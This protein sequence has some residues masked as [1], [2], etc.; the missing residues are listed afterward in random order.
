MT[1]RA[2]KLIIAVVI[3]LVVALFFVGI[4]AA[5]AVAGYRAAVRAGNEAATLQNLKTIAV[6]E[7]QYADSHN[8]NFA[9]LDDLVSEKLVSSKF[10]HCPTIADGY[11]I[12][13]T[14]APKPDGDSWYRLTADPQDTTSGHTHFYFDSADRRIH[15]NGERQ[16]GPT[17]SVN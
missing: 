9:T 7:L 12:T 16:A 8:R 11:V 6:A 14:L 5:A 1:S 15:V 17:D 3:I 10:S 13:L 4:V 2:Q